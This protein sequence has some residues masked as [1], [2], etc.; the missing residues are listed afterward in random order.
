MIQVHDNVLTDPLA[1]RAAAV[2]QPVQSMTFGATTFHGLALAPDP[3]FLTW[4]AATYPAYAPTL[5]FLRT[6]PAGQIEPN[7]IHTD[8]DMGDVTAL[9]YLNP[10]PPPKDGTT[11][12]QHRA[13]GATEGDA[14]VRDGHDRD[15]WDVVQHVPARFNRCVVFTAPLFHSRA[16]VANYGHDADA[17][18]VQVLFAKEKD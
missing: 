7:D 8:V 4:F 18:V 1:Y 17:R 3:A 9:L 15:A 13:S 2:A 10:D 16:L 14:W 11:F 12:W 5:T 6:S